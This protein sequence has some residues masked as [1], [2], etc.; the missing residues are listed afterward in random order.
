MKKLTALLGIDHLPQEVELTEMTLDSRSAK[1]GC[2]FVAI[3][4]HQTDGRNYIPQAIANGASAVLF[5]ADFAQQHLT[6]K[7]EQGIP[8]IAYYALP[9]H[10]SAIAGAFYGDPS[11]QLTL[12]GVTGTNGKTT[13]A[14]LVAQWANLLAHKSAVM[15]TIGN[16]LLGQIK[17]ATNTTGSAIEI[18]S[19]LAEFV[20]AGADFAAI[21][22]SSHGLVQ[23]RVEAL[24]FAVAIF[25]NLSRDHLDYHHTMENYAAAKFRLFNELDCQHKVINADDPVGAQWLQQLPNAI[26]V[27]CKADYQPSHKQWLKAEQVQF[28]N[29]GAIIHFTSSWGK[30]ELHSPL[31]GAFNVSNLLFAFASLLA[32]GYSL[33][34]L[35]QSAGQLQGVCGR[36][37]RLN[38]TNQATAI[39]DY[40]H[41]P[42]ALEKALQAARLHCEGALYCVFGC[43]GDRDTGKRPQMARIA[44]QFTDFVIVTDDNPRTE[45]AEKIMQDIQ[46][47]F[48]DLANV[49][50]IHQR[51]QAIQQALKMAQPQDVVLIA[52]KGHEDYQII[53]TTKLPFSDQAT[54]KQYFSETK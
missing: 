45:D 29:Q 11:H 34:E 46:A 1:T 16:G 49:Q 19:T 42:D 15:G 35:C 6:I 41:T 24:K 51:D 54:V 31:I 2:L 13:V 44:E 7:M 3:K 30:G 20:Q 47:G 26:A 23:H 50:I 12:V 32:L 8:L 18:Q 10:L 22:V 17:E 36:M 40:A 14:Q 37:E 5:E 4:G 9:E 53:G 27:S 38:A 39:V 33:N 43:G 21:E 25:T 28:H 48:V 52:G